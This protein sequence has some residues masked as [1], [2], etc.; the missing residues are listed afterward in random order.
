MGVKVGPPI[1]EVRHVAVRFGRKEVLRGVSVTVKAGSH[2]AIIGPNGAG[3][4]T[5]LKAMDGLL[6][7]ASGEILLGGRLLSAWS[8]KEVARK[9]AY[10]PQADG[11]VL[12]FPARD[13]VLMGRYPHLS[14]LSAIR[15]QD[16]DAAD[17]A[18]RVTG[19]VQFADR[20][21]DTLSGGERQKLF[22]A[23]AIAQGAEILLLDEPTT[24]LDPRH[25]ADVLALL[26]RLNRDRG[27]TLLTVT[28][29]IN[30][31]ALWADEVLALKDGAVA[32]SGRAA[33]AMDNRVLG[34][35]FDHEFS[36]ATRDDGRRFVLPEG[37]AQRD[38]G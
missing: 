12:P 2:V 9:V 13:F 7:V 31:A 23:A 34:A 8:R 26:A 27:V 18:M 38:G 20:R 35:V 4:S 1:L 25:Q 15:R 14:P 33:D 19:T 16:R 11:R 30:A 5:L 17:D 3:K 29:D 36:F 24:F 32:W 37:G 21:V 22:I 6:P 28:H 10:V